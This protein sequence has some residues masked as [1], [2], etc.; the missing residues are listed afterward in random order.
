MC[1]DHRLL[2]R[3]A[4][5]HLATLM[6]ADQKALLPGKLQRA[7]SRGPRLACTG[8][9][10]RSSRAWNR[11]QQLRSLVMHVPKPHGAVRV[12]GAVQSRVAAAAAVVC[13]PTAL[14]RAVLR[15]T[16]AAPAGVWVCWATP[17]DNPGPRVLVRGCSLGLLAA[18][19][20]LPQARH[21]RTL[22]HA[23]T[24]THVCDTYTCQAA[25]TH[26]A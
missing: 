1:D 6:A 18:G 17:L 26:V 11:A 7:D 16:T 14:E 8:Q 24:C 22:A 13:V 15:P 4:S 21:A 10:M 9:R 20:P 2:V 23:H 25:S 3:E 5:T 12:T 19:C